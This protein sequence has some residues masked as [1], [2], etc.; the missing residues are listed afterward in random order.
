MVRRR[1][2]TPPKAGRRPYARVSVAASAVRTR[3]GNRFISLVVTL[4]AQSDGVVL[5]VHVGLRA[6]G[7]PC[8]V[9][10][11][12]QRRC[13]GHKGYAGT[14]WSGSLRHPRRGVSRVKPVSNEWARTQ[15]VSRSVRGMETARFW[16]PWAFSRC[17]TEGRPAAPSGLT[18]RRSRVQIPPPLRRSPWESHN[19]QGFLTFKAPTFSIRWSNSTPLPPVPPSAGNSREHPKTEE[20]DGPHLMTLGSNRAPLREILERAASR[21]GLS[22]GSLGGEVRMLTRS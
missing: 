8:T 1:I 9:R 2:L 13:P 10:G 21:R 4:A 15:R 22:E 3:G 6:L 14:S 5:C 20:P 17:D 19:S 12:W 16:A 7:P 11:D 18:T